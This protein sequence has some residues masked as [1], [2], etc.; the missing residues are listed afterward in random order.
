MENFIFAL[1]IFLSPRFVT[2]GLHQFCS[3]GVAIPLQ[4]ANI[5]SLLDLFLILVFTVPTAAWNVSSFPSQ[6]RHS[7]NLPLSSNT[8]NA[9]KDQ[10][11]FVIN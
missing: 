8:L 7:Y 10:K 3:A 4:S 1:C 2:H 6:Q 11:F 9:Y 5:L